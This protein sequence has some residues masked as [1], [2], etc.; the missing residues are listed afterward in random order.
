NSLKRLSCGNDL[1]QLMMTGQKGNIMH[2]IRK[3]IRDKGGGA[4]VP[5]VFPL[6]LLV[7][8]GV[9]FITVDPIGT[10]LA[11]Q[12]N[13]EFVKLLALLMLLFFASVQDLR[14]NIV[15]NKYA[16]M[17]F[18]LGLINVSLDSVV[19]FAVCGGAFFIVAL[20]TNLGGADV[21]I[22]A[23][24]AFVMGTIPTLFALLIG[25][26]MSIIMEAVVSLKRKE[27][28]MTRHYPLVPY[29]SFGCM[30]VMILKGV[31]LL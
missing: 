28:I 6:F 5:V 29:I 9:L 8:A 7:V 13:W 1:P 17:I 26:S 25:L 16:I 15:D 10:N 14:E 27:N 24:T 11:S 20:L 3:L 19:A 4:S 12:I 18:L 30:V 22:T 31:N 23:A 21:K 2:K